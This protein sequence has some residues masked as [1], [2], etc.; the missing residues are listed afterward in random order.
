MTAGN[1][2]LD[3][4]EKGGGRADLDSSATTSTGWSRP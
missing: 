3:L 1:K 2:A 4:H